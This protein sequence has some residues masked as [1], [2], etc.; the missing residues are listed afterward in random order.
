MHEYICRYFCVV[1][2]IKLKADVEI[3]FFLTEPGHTC[4]SDLNLFCAISKYTGQFP[5]VNDNVWWMH[6]K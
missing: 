2:V 4:I 3:K 6:D 1:Y 5:H